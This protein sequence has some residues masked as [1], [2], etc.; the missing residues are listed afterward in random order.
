LE[1]P[2]IESGNSWLDDFGRSADDPDFDEYLREISRAQA[3]DAPA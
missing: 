1:V 2:V 3:A